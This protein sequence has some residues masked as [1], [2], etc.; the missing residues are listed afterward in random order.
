VAVP[1]GVV[2]AVAEVPPTTV[3]VVAV[4]FQVAGLQ[5]RQ[6]WWPWPARLLLHVRMMPV[7]R[8]AGA[9]ATRWQHHGVEMC[10]YLCVCVCVCVCVCTRSVTEERAATAT[11]GT[12]IRRCHTTVVSRRAQQV[13]VHCTGM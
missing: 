13:V 9:R 12:T 11:C 2:A 6:Q 10:V 7:V 1:S 5:Q 3:T 8:A 4:P